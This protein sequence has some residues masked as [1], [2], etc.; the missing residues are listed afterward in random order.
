[1]FDIKSSMLKQLDD[2]LFQRILN[3]SKLALVISNSLFFKRRFKQLE[4]IFLLL[5]TKK[6]NIK[7]LSF[8]TFFCEKLFWVK[9][10]WKS[11]K[12]QNKKHIWYF[13]F[14]VWNET[15]TLK[16]TTKI[17]NDILFTLSDP[18]WKLSKSK[19]RKLKITSFLLKYF[20]KWSRIKGKRC[21]C[22]KINCW[23]IFLLHLCMQYLEGQS[24]DNKIV[25]KDI[26]PSI[27]GLILV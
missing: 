20:I 3:A 15:F 12:Y 11:T 18:K 24:L 19:I 25:L 21:K 16:L 2:I 23:W 22:K 13:L 9:S 14:F 7:N 1:M 10:E 17:P 26:F 4:A 8:V 27:N 6:A 5:K